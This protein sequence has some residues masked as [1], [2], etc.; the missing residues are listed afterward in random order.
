MEIYGWAKVRGGDF[1]LID[2][3]EHYK[4]LLKKIPEVLI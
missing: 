3:K 4:L 2:E 1:R